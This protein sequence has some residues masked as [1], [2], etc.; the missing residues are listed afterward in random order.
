[1]FV[2]DLA[3]LIYSVILHE[4]AHGYVADLLGDPTARLSKRLTL[5]PIPHI[6]PIMTIA[7]PALLA[8]SGSGIIFGA[9]KP[10]PVDPFNFREPKKDMALVALA[11]PLTNLGIAVILTILFRVFSLTIS[12][13]TALSTILQILG[14][15]IT[16]NVALAIFN[17]FP[18]P[19]L[20]GFK[21]LTG[22]LPDEISMELQRLERFGFMLIFFVLFF[23][24]SFIFGIIAPIIRT[25]TNLLLP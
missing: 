17:L 14:T 7:L 19:P 15:A 12:N 8:F 9:A 20:D 2:V 23:F 25:I 13:E 3:I 11:G 24:P 5:N 1:M 21:V 6:D 4:I 16:W 10:V 22:L 18:L